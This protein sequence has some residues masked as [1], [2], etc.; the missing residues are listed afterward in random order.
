MAKIELNDG[1]KIPMVKPT[2][3]DSAEVER[4]MGWNRKEYA[5]WMKLSSM[6]TAL[7]VFASLRRA[8][9]E[10][11]FKEVADLD[12]VANI[13]AEP[14]DL[15]REKESE[16]KQSPDPHQGSATAVADVSETSP[17]ATPS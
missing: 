15:A 5:D 2:L 4:E 9:I 1:R 10:T 8:G 13:I 7:Q 6:Q 11:T 17:T 14:R 16:G 3:W 12:L